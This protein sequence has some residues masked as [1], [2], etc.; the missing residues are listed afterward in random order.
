MSGFIFTPVKPVT[1]AEY[2]AVISQ[3][4][5]NP[6]RAH[7]WQGAVIFISAV[8]MA[9]FATGV[10]AAVQGAKI[11]FFTSL[12]VPTGIVQLAAG[13]LLTCV[14]V[15]QMIALA[16]ECNSNKKYHQS[17]VITEAIKDCKKRE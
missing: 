9:V 5:P 4:P 12:F 7:L 17:T 1:Y 8:A 16:R 6:S 14:G 2:Y 15:P 11:L 10:F 3:N 13:L